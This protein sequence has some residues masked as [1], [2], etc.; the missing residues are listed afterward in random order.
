M[1][2]IPEKHVPLQ[3]EQPEEKR[4]TASAV[5]MAKVQEIVMWFH[6]HLERWYPDCIRSREKTMAADHT[7]P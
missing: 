1:M 6:Y 2:N 7:I 5:L 4:D 3:E